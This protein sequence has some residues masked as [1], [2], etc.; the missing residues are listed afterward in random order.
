MYAMN[1]VDVVDT[2]TNYGI[3]FC[4]NDNIS[5]EQ[6]QNQLL[7]IKDEF[8]KSDTDWIVEDI[9]KEMP[10]EWQVSLQCNSKLVII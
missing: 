1:L 6:I 9:I 5:V 3:L 8:V 4:G 7:K 10:C 2:K